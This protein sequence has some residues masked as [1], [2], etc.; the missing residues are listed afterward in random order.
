VLCS[1]VICAVAVAVSIPMPKPQMNRASSR[2][3]SS[4]QTRK[5]SAAKTLSTT[6]GAIILRRPNLSEI[7]PARKRLTTTPAAYAAKMSV[8]VKALKPFRCW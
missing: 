7:C 8:T 4:G 3:G 2:P 5:T 6:A 1:S